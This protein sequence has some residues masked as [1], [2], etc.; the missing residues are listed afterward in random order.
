MSPEHY[1]GSEISGGADQYSLGV[2]AYQCL[3]GRVPFDASTA[4]ELLNK[5][6]S[7]PPPP[8]AEARPGLPPHAYAAIER[9]LA[10]APTAR[11]ATVSDFV[12][13]LAGRA[14]AVLAPRA[15]RLRRR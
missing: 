13:A 12:S 9:A 6:M 1:R 8:L 3:G 10:K 2:V 14:P 11:F 4:Y 15:V 5:H 7:Q